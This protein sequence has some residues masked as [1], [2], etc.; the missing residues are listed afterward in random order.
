MTAGGLVF[1]GATNDNRF[2]AFDSRTGR[3][4]WFTDNGRDWMGDD[5][6]PDELIH[7]LQEGKVY[8]PEQAREAMRSFFRK[9][10]LIALR[11]LALRRTAE[12]VDAQMQAYMRDHAIGAVWPTAERLLVA[13]SASP[14]SVRLVRA[15]KRMAERLGADWWVSYVE[16]PAQLRLPPEAK[17]QVAQTLRLAESLGAKTVTLTGARMSDEILAFAR[18]RNVTRIVV[19]KPQRSL[20]KRIVLGSI[21]DALVQGS[22]DIDIA[23][24][25]GDKDEPAPTPVRRRLAPPEWSGYLQAVAAVVLA[26]GLSWLMF[27]LFEVSNLVMVYLLGIVLVFALLVI[28]AIAWRRSWSRR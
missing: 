1:L 8:L 4:L 12:R 2:R 11:E 19:G 26:T 10:N 14:F 20:W 22:G 16:T 21:V 18:Q 23:V 27:P 13:V 5:R 28:A 15:G 25:S 7:R 17:D 24:I 3:E 6:P 9:G